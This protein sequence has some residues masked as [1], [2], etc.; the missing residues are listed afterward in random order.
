MSSGTHPDPIVLSFHESLLRVSD[1]Q[2]L[3]GPHWLNDQIISFYFE[4]LEKE[5]YKKNCDMLFISPE[6]THCIKIISDSEIDVFLSP[7]GAN[8]KPFIFFALNDNESHRVGG[9]HWSLLVFS[10][11]ERAFFHFDSSIGSS[12][13][14]HCQNFVNKIKYALKCSNAITKSIRC[15]QQTNSYDCGIHVL[16]MA[17]NV[18]DHINRYE[19]VDGVEQLKH[20]TISRKRSEILKIISDLGGKIS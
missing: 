18:S 3:Q 4:Y 13:L 19:M 5:K 17:D 2:L 16:C 20:D 12:N 10:R 7:L 1:V 9:S 11:P 14:S 15:L 6:V 8:K